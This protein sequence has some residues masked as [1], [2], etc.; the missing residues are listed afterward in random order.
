MAFSGQTQPAIFNSDRQP[1][2]FSFS[3]LRVAQQSDPFAV[4][5][6][7][8]QFTATD[9]FLDT[10]CGTD[11]S[12]LPEKRAIETI[13]FEITPKDDAPFITKVNLFELPDE[14]NF[15]NLLQ[16]LKQLRRSTGLCLIG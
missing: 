13:A 6:Y 8:L 15:R 4:T 10:D 16:H 9:Q 5:T 7:Y 12:P 14:R 2:G 3:P 11:P 1:Y